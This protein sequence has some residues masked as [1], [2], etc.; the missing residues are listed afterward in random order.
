MIEI[1]KSEIKDAMRSS[2]SIRLKLLRMVMSEIQKVAISEKRK[3]IT[4]DDLI[5]AVTSGI[6]ER[7][8]AIL[9]FDKG[10]A[11]IITKNGSIDKETE[12][13]SNQGIAKINAEIEVYKEFL[14]LQLTDDEVEVLVDKAIA[15]TGATLRKEMG[16]IICRVKTEIQSGAYEMKRLSKMVMSKLN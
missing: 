11:D 14:P 7:K 16:R 3:D 4:E 2:Q 6:S 8:N 10:I 1:L 15:G 5:K 9:K 13:K 12:D